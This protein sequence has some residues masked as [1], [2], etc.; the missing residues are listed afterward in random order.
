MTFVCSYT[1]GGFGYVP[2]S[3]AFPH[4]AYEV[5]ISRFCETTGDDFADE[6]IRLLN[7]CKNQ[8]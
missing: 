4:G 1:N 3:I 8:K 7:N 5:L 6:M 2:S